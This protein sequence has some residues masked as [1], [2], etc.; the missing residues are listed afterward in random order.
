MPGRSPTSRPNQL[1]RWGFRCRR[2]GEGVEITALSAD[3]MRALRRLRVPILVSRSGKVDRVEPFQEGLRPER[4]LGGGAEGAAS[5][6][7]KV[8]GVEPSRKAYGPSAS[9]GGGRRRRSESRD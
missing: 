6:S 9:S 5:R 3:L 8:D 1:G 7:G 2:S 4:K